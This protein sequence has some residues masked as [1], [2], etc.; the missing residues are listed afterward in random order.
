M[1]STNNYD[2]S[3]Y[4]FEPKPVYEIIKRIMDLTSAITLLIL[5]S[6]VMCVIAIIL[7]ISYGKKIFYSQER[8]GR[9]GKNFKI[10]KFRTMKLNAEESEPVWAQPNDLRCTFIGKILRKT[11]LD[12]LPQLANIISGELSLVG[13]RP[14]RPYFMK[15]HIGLSGK[16]LLV[17]PGLTGLAQV[18]G[19]Y[20]LTIEEKLKFDLEY[21]HNRRFYLDI[22]IMIKTI[23]VIL[24]CEGAW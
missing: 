12:E 5:L 3:L 20:K 16:R 8:V 9:H 21:V 19:R 14:E 7:K 11:S 6:P 2:E 4:I 13:P 1:T 23:P 18:N 15:D 24:S 10:H 22:K 17:K